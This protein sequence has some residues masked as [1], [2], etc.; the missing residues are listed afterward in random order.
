MR[1][2]VEGA[3]AVRVEYM[4]S[5]VASVGHDDATVGGDGDV[6]YMLKLPSPVA[7]RPKCEGKCAVGV[8]DMNAVVAGIGYD[9]A[10]VG[11]DGSVWCGIDGPVDAT[12][13]SI[14]GPVDIVG[15]RSR[16]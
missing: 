6:Y 13:R 10:T 4:D 12:G 16:V 2:K 7:E 15:N 1:P 9:D 5:A 3:R 14:V 8:I 11:G